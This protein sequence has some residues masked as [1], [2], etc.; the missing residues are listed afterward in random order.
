MKE[1]LAWLAS[2]STL[3]TLVLTGLD[4]AWFHQGSGLPC[5]VFFLLGRVFR[6]T[7]EVYCISEDVGPLRDFLLMGRKGTG[8]GYVAQ[9]YLEIEISASSS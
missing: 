6:N 8:S 4:V 2:F 7:A 1:C 3:Q 9:G 5:V